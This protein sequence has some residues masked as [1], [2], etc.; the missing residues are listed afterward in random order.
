VG[1]SD[2]SSRSRPRLDRTRRCRQNRAAAIGEAMPDRAPSGPSDWEGPEEVA[3]E[4][5]PEGPQDA[6]PSSHG[7]SSVEIR[8]LDALDGEAISAHLADS[9]H[10]NICHGGYR[11]GARHPARHRSASAQTRL[12]RRGRGARSFLVLDDPAS[13]PLRDLREEGVAEGGKTVHPMGNPIS[14]STH[15]GFNAPALGGGELPPRS[16]RLTAS[17]KVR[18]ALD[19]EGRRPLRI[20]ASGLIRPP[21]PSAALGVGQRAT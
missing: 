6:V 10:Q 13:D 4:G 7:V 20:T 9:G 3:A 14:H 17:R 18:C 19:P 5:P 15:V 21:F 8:S 12:A 11:P 1:R 2:S 16:S